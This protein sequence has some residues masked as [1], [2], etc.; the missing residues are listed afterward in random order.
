MSSTDKEDA[1]KKQLAGYESIAV[2]YSGG[3]DSTYLA[4]VA[5]DVMGSRAHMILADS[6]SIP[7]TEVEEAVALANERGWELTVISTSEFEN[8]DYLQNDQRR[9][10]HC[11][12]ELFTCMTRYAQENGIAR[13][14]YGAMQDDLGDYRPGHDAAREFEVLAPL[15][16][17]EMSKEEIREQSRQ[18]ELPTWKKASFACLASRFP[19][20][21]AI[22][23]EKISRVEQ[24]EEVLRRLGFHQFRARHHDDL[25]RIEV[26]GE[27]IARL[28]EPETR[29]EAEDAIRGLGYRY[30][31]VDLSGYRT[32]ST[33]G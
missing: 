6:P 16:D 11:K 19:T 3:V 7:R 14:A 17:V 8:P 18:R 24:A 9:C 32:G 21:T 15:Q 1:L 25:C 12:A 26:D 5:H 28:M 2:A 22:T 20:G 4:D 10:Y 13:L 29:K 27:D 23:R 30:V 31:T 33:A